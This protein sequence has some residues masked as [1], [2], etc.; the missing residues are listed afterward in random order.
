MNVSRV[1]GSRQARSERQKGKRKEK[2]CLHKQRVLAQSRVNINDNDKEN[3]RRT[4][5]SVTL[6]PQTV[7]TLNTV[8]LELA[9]VK[10]RCEELEAENTRLKK[11]PRNVSVLSSHSVHDL[12]C[13]GSKP[14]F[15]TYT[16]THIYTNLHTHN[17]MNM[18]STYT[19]RPT[20]I[21]QTSSYTRM[22]HAYT[23]TDGGDVHPVRPRLE[24][25]KGYF[26]SHLTLRFVS[27][28]RH[29]IPSCQSYTFALR[30]SN[31]TGGIS[32][33][34]YVK[35]SP[36][37][38][39][40]YGISFSR[41]PGESVVCLDY[42]QIIINHRRQGHGT[43]VLLHLLSWFRSGGTK[44]VFVSTPST[45]GAVFYRKLGFE[46]MDWGDYVYAF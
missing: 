5:P 21:A 1:L 9:R 11:K 41:A 42:F 35:G 40:N 2:T 33:M 31:N 6:D 39:H 20:H 45:V 30:A 29:C 3:G 18:C 17:V 4:G 14:I 25:H 24:E 22:S 12:P 26:K 36:L 43:R 28:V 13:D 46:R 32:V 19:Y 15:G 10:K 23:S 37:V 27:H 7:L 34:V 8:V 44:T 16:R 38:N